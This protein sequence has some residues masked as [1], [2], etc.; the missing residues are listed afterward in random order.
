M[1]YNHKKAVE[2]LTPEEYEENLQ[3]VKDSYLQAYTGQ[4]V[5]CRGCN[6]Q[7][8]LYA[9]YRCFFCGSYYCRLCSKEHFGDR[10]L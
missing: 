5:T 8:P 7:F 3:W 9:L 4:K 2:D 6:R 10:Q 1:A